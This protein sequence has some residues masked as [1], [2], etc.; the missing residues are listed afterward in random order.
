MSFLSSIAHAVG[1]VVTAPIKLA[2]DVDH[3]IGKGLSKIPVLGKPLNAVFDLGNSP[4][5]VSAG[6]A[7]GHPISAVLKKE[8]HDQV[9]DIKTAGPYAQMV[10]S[11][12]PGVGTVASAAIGAGLALANG[13]PLSAAFVAGVA[14]AIPGGPVAQAAFQAAQSGLQGKPVN[15]AAIAALPIDD[16]QKQA[17]TVVTNYT[18]KLGHGQKPDDQA[19]EA[20][21]KKLPPDLQKATAAGVM[22]GQAAAAQHYAAPTVKVDILEQLRETGSDVIARDSVLTAGLT[23]LPSLDLSDGFTIG[24]GLSVRAATPFEIVAIRNKLPSQEE[25][26]GYDLAL[27]YH[28]GRTGF[29]APHGLTAAQTF[30]M[31]CTHG[32]T[33]VKDPSERAELGRI[34]NYHPQ[35]KTGMHLG[36][37]YHQAKRG[38][39]WHR[40]LVWLGL[41]V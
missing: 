26:Y 28:V 27:A 4:V 17:L 9:K 19:Y 29:P 38:S 11:F 5:K 25:R 34:L 3:V 2:D 32:L 39:W 23:S 8:I 16:Q 7:A 36:V 31:I 24:T 35:V 12:V 15:Q 20:A 21:M 13:Q 10:L 33:T 37:M 14:G 1:S 6:I 40:F 41:A 30:G 22:V 18:S